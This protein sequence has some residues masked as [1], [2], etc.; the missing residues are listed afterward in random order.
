M[1][2]GISGHQNISPEVI[3]YVKPILVRLITERKKDLVGVSSLAAGA[4]QLFASTIL[5]QGGSLQAMIPC[6]GY[7]GT[8]SEPDGLNQ[9]KSLLAR[10][11]KVETLEYPK[12]SE[13]AFLDA[14]CRVVDNSDLLIAVWD[15]EPAAG[16]G[17]TADIVKYA[18]R[19]GV[20]VIVV[21]PPGSTR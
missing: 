1:R 18:N 2:L 7:E 15:G 12:P 17:G 9:F 19:R 5:D 8:F 3:A 16:K 20:K 13:E 14:G 10:A 6:R 4:D 11:K 21:W